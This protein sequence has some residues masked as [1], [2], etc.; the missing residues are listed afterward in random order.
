MSSLWR[1]IR[2]CPLPHHERLLLIIIHPMDGCIRVW[3]ASGLSG[4]V[5]VP[6]VPEVMCYKTELAQRE[7]EMYLHLSPELMF[8]L[9]DWF[10]RLDFI[11]FRSINFH[12]F[13]NVDLH[14]LFFEFF[15][16][17]NWYHFS[18]KTR[19][20]KEIITLHSGPSIVRHIWSLQ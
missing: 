4:P 5:R 9:I 13:C 14:L 15:I 3:Q 20:S 2:K 6:F 11:F 19:A 7:C 16:L 1:S 17:K 12:P 8:G 18:T 10:L